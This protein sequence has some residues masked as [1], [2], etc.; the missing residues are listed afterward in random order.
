VDREAEA[1]QQA[2]GKRVLA[3]RCAGN[4]GAVAVENKRW[5]EV[6]SGCLVQVNPLVTPAH[7][8]DGFDRRRLN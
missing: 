3:L 1:G 7:R 4:T 8:I 6:T 2:R 5:V